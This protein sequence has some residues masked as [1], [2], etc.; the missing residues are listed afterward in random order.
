LVTEKSLYEDP[1]NLKSSKFGAQWW[2]SWPY[3][4]LDPWEP[5]PRPLV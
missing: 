2:S 4:V 3:L 5:F 1:G